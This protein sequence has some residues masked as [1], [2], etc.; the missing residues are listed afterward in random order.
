MQMFSKDVFDVLR[1]A[2]ERLEDLERRVDDVKAELGLIRLGFLRIRQRR[3]ALLK[4]GLLVFATWL[5]GSVSPGGSATPMGGGRAGSLAGDLSGIAATVAHGAGV[6]AGVAFDLYG[7]VAPPLIATWGFVAG[8]VSQG[9]V[10][11]KHAAV[12]VKSLV[13]H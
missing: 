11:A 13:M 9:A 1:P 3:A 7:V 5:V 8:L 2:G 12:G 10:Y 4:L 6:V